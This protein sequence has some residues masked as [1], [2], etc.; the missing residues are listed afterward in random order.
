[1]PVLNNNSKT[2]ARPDL[3]TQLLQILIST[4]I[5]VSTKG[6]LHFSHALDDGLLRKYL[7]LGVS[8]IV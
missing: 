1:M 3:A 8:L 2:S 4:T 5:I 7:Q 6:I